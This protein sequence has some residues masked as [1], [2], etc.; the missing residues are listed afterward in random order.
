MDRI[1]HLCGFRLVLYTENVIMLYI[2]TA[3][4]HSVMLQ[5]NAITQEGRI[6]MEYSKSL[7]KVE[8]RYLDLIAAQRRLMI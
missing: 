5:H 6:I 8:K 2:D 4:L 1:R 7:K 3:Q